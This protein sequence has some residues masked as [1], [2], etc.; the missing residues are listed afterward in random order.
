LNRRLLERHFG[1]TEVSW[2][3]P[4]YL[5]LVQLPASAHQAI[6]VANSEKFGFKPAMEAF[7]S[8]YKHAGN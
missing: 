1:I 7:E 5:P 6:N 2:A 3:A 4:L 8:V